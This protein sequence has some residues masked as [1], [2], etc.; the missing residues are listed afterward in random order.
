MAT[1][2]ANISKT[3]QQQVRLMIL[4]VLP[5]FSLTNLGAVSNPRTAQALQAL[6]FVISGFGA[7]WNAFVGSANNWGAPA[8]PGTCSLLQSLPG[9]PLSAV[10]DP[11]V[12][13][14]VET[15][16]LEPEGIQA[17]VRAVFNSSGFEAS[18]A[19]G[20]V[21]DLAAVI[22]KPPFADFA[23]PADLLAACQQV[24]AALGEPVLWSLTGDGGA[25]VPQ[26]PGL[27]GGLPGG[28][29]IPIPGQPGGGLPGLPQVPPPPPA[30]PPPEEGLSTNAKIAIGVGVGVAVVGLVAAV[31]LSGG[32]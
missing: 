30:A 29:P 9:V 31:A 8:T 6:A 24:A 20:R 13:M 10:N 2:N 23:A 25:A 5:L 7:R 14:C 17:F 32:K 22:K 26:L 1:W 15:F 18:L 21:H 3:R 27:P 28:I 16:R 12:N 19:L 4:G 11:S